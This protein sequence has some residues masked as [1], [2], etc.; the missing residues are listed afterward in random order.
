MSRSTPRIGDEAPSEEKSA[1][2]VQLPGGVTIMAVHGDITKLPVEVIVN[3]ANSR[4]DHIGGLAKDIANKG[5]YYINQSN[6]LF[7]SLNNKKF[8]WQ[9]NLQ[10]H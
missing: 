4:L 1:I 8:I 10:I 2:T 9:I 5:Y 3:A 6:R 7:S